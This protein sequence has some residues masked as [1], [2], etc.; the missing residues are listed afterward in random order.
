M[1]KISGKDKFN[2]RHDG[3]MIISDVTIRTLIVK[4]IDEVERIKMLNN[5][6]YNIK[7]KKISS[8]IYEVQLIH[9]VGDYLERW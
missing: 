4:G 6:E 1:N 5:N 3:N 8:D 2:N 7:S 9:R